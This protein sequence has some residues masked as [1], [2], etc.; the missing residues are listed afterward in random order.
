MSIVSLTMDR[1]WPYL[2]KGQH[3][4]WPRLLAIELTPGLCSGDTDNGLKDV[5]F[6]IDKGVFYRKF[7]AC[8]SNKAGSL[9]KKDNTYLNTNLNKHGIFLPK[10]YLVRSSSSLCNN[11]KKNCT[12]YLF[13]GKTNVYVR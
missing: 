6:C 4:T 3:P 11:T 5:L 1:Q 9:K 10:K 2:S 7:V 12:I 13:F 8:V